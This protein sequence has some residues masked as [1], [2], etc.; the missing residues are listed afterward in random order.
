MAVL[1]VGIPCV[2]MGLT[3]PY[4]CSLAPKD[5]R[6]PSR[7]YAANTFGACTAV[8]APLVFPPAIRASAEPQPARPK[9][10]F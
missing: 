2:L 5:A 9:L 6:F 4:L 10:T 8:R 7:L 3:F 1:A